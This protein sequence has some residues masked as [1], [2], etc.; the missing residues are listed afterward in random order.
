MS[1]RRAAISFIVLSCLTGPTA[2]LAANP[3]FELRSTIVFTSTRHN[4]DID[5]L[6]AAEIYL[7]DPDGSHPRRLTNNTSADAFAALSPDGKRVVF[8]SNRNRAGDEP[9]NVSDLYVMKADGSEQTHIIRGSSATWSP[10]GRNIA[11]HAS[12]SGTGLLI[13][14]DLGSPAID[15]DIFSLNLDDYLAGTASPRNLTNSPGMIERDPDWSP[16][17]SMIVFVRH[18]VGLPELADV[19]R[20]NVDGSGLTPLTFFMGEERTPSWSPDG[21]RIV[22]TARR[23]GGD[24]EIATTD[25]EGPHEFL[26]TNNQVPDGS[27]T[28]SPDG[29]MIVFHRP[30][31][32]GLN[33]LWT[34]HLAGGFEVP[35]T[36][37]PGMNLIADWGVLRV[38]TMP[39]AAVREIGAD[40]RE[41]AADERTA[42][43]AGRMSL[44]LDPIHPNPA[45][46]G[47]NLSFAVPATGQVRL[48]VYDAAGRRVATVLEA[49]MPAGRRSVAWN[50]LDRRGHPVPTGMYFAKLEAGGESQ[51]RKIVLAR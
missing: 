29:Q 25:A 21:A 18:P 49:T 31:A 22:Y 16:D 5:P 8:D 14:P 43:G 44:Q 4:P 6:D 24:F 39:G 19:Y 26:L 35:I 42:A 38:H 12:A 51:V 32:F 7:I 34:M 48:T 10:N 15:S 2:G 40:A 47:A 33:Q 45:K 46:A 37:G 36:S 9:I 11:Y 20:M 3:P 27:P 30:D 13:R 17:G 28:W 23:G 50:G 41:A 1:R